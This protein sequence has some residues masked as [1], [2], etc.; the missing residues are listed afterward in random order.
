MV[1]KRHRKMKQTW[2][3]LVKLYEEVT[4][5]IPMIVKLISLNKF[6]INILN[7]RKICVDV[8]S[9]NH[10]REQKDNRKK[11]YYD[12]LEDKMTTN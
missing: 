11:I 1:T 6:C 8:V 9:K 5:Y 2:K 4:V 7:V 10:N 3:K 12:V